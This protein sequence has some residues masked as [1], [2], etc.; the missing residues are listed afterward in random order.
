[1]LKFNWKQYE[2]SRTNKK[3]IQRIRKSLKEISE[4]AK[5][6]GKKIPIAFYLRVSTK[7]KPQEQALK[8]Q[9]KFM[10]KFESQ[11]P[12][13]EVSWF[14]DFGKTGT[15]GKRDDFIRMLRLARN[16]KFA[17]IVAR[18][19]SRFARNVLLTLKETDELRDEENIGVYFIFD[20]I[21]TFIPSD[22]MRLLEKAKQAE[23]EAAR[24]SMRVHATIDNQIEYD[25][26]S[27]EAYGP[28]R[29]ASNILGYKSDKS[30]RHYWLID[31]EGSITV[32]KMFDLADE[33]YTVAQ[34]TDYMEC[35]GYKTKTGST[36]WHDSTVYRILTNPIYIGFQYQCKETILEEHFLNKERTKLPKE[37]WILV[38]VSE[39]VPK[40]IKEDKFERVQEKVLS[41]QT[42]NFKKG[43]DTANKEQ[44]RDMWTQILICKCGRKYKCVN[45]SAEKKNIMYQCYNQANNGSK[46]ARE[47]KGLSTDGA[48][49]ISSIPLWKLMMMEKMIT[50][51]L[52]SNLDLSIEKT[53][54]AVKTY[55]V[56]TVENESDDKKYEKQQIKN[57]IDEIKQRKQRLAKMYG[58]GQ[59]D[60]DDY[61]EEYRRADTEQQK[62]KK[63]LQDMNDNTSL[64]GL[65]DMLVQ[66]EAVLRNVLS[67]FNT[68][69]R[70]IHNVVDAIVH[71]A[72]NK[73]L[74][75][76]NFDTEHIASGLE[77]N[78][79][80]FLKNDYSKNKTVVKDKSL[81]F[82]SF[83]ITKDIAEKFKFENKLGYVRDWQDIEVEV[84]F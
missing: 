12:E 37:D 31:D 58:L 35:H 39:Y 44:N 5:K 60:D 16:G 23:E 19:V 78:E 65:D 67:G 72:D 47:A 61:K 22:R 4:E 71:E 2:T 53:L 43:N 57:A 20:D 83:T 80:S 8:E 38:D 79:I 18:E 64:E 14:I 34:I 7:N 28:P 24:T 76:L 75:F 32:N 10:E 13:W 11:H 46:A 40:L 1:M 26:E 81:L 74:W 52:V 62:L 36:K 41:R 63:Q 82:T 59:M 42:T 48:C 3:I 50:E 17:Y 45:R 27:G 21:D 49:D 33:D 69:Q 84:Y 29:G 51:R 66:T 55:N 15:N 25:K 68:E 56:V 6:T 30:R 54:E 70:L 73:F 77:E 9:K